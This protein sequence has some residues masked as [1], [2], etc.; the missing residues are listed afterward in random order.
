MKK[1]LFSV[2]SLLL[3]CQGYAQKMTVKD[4]DSN[5]LMEVNDEGTVGT[6]L[7]ED[8]T[9]APSVTT[10][11]LY[12]VGGDLYWNGGELAVGGSAW[13]LSGNSGT[14]PGTNFIGT[15]DEKALEFKAYNRRIL[16]MEPVT[17]SPNLIGGH[18]G[19]SVA[20]GV[21]GATIGGGGTSG[22]FNQVTDDLGTIGGG[23]NNLAGDGAGMTSDRYCA[24]VGGG[25]QN[26][27]S[28][29]YATIG[30]GAG[31]QADGYIATVG[32]GHLNDADGQWSTVPG[33]ASNQ[34]DGDFS[35]AAG[36]RAKAIHTGAFVWADATE[37][38]FSSSGANQFIIRASGGVGIGKN[39]PAHAL[40][41]NGEILSTYGFFH[42]RGDPGA[43]DKTIGGW[44]ADG[45]WY[46]WDLSSVVPAGAKSIVL[47]GYVKS[48]QAGESFLARKNGNVNEYNVLQAITQAAG[49][50]AAFQA[51]IPCDENRIIEYKFQN[52]GNWTDA[53][54]TVVGWYK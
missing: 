8:S 49:V 29:C 48:S 18:E 27:A 51:I 4:S 15:I 25:S 39:D 37:A 41:V 42:D 34:A 38:D 47:R 31:N 54:A 6:I 14:T 33:G 36:R 32:G 35:M 24:T 10:N 40:D 20:A 53:V 23:N 44:T 1:I 22:H 30:G 19:N 12:N 46:D 3:V 9:E 5:V 43:H 28:G 17:D 52:T 26:S 13:N 16:R 2:I 45:T 11:K 50:A 7:L 21:Y